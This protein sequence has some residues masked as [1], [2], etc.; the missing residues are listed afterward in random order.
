[1]IEVLRVA[2]GWAS[3]FGG[4][5][6]SLEDAILLYPM[7]LPNPGLPQ[8]EVL[9]PVLTDGAINEFNLVGAGGTGSRVFNSGPFTVAL[10]IFNPQNIFTAGPLRDNDGIMPGRNVIL[11]DGAIWRDSASLGVTGDWVIYAIYRPS[12]CGMFPDCNNNGMDD[13]QEI[14]NDPSIDC[15]TN[16]VIDSCEIAANPM[17]DMNG[18][19][20]L[21]ECEPDCPADITGNGTVNGADLAEVLGSWGDCPTEGPC[22]GDL[23]G[24]GVVNG[25]DL[26]ELLGSWGD[27]K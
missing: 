1:P 7:G 23:T 6:D 24:N 21:D 13:N 26:G 12:D 9:G 10:S 27:C 8:F 20:I 22:P 19:G 17:L 3:Q 5:P 4:T 16:N 18:N 11:Q 2:F 14:L 15:N 25:A